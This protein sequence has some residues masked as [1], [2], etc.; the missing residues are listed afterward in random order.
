M[1]D[2]RNMTM[3]IVLAHGLPGSGKSTMLKNLYNK[4]VAADKAALY[5]NMDMFPKHNRGYEGA[6]S[7]AWQIAYQRKHKEDHC[8]NFIDDN[9][10]QYLDVLCM[11]NAEVIGVIM[12]VVARFAEC[13]QCTKYNFTILDFNEDRDMCLKNNAIRTKVNPERSAELT[14]KRANYEV[15]DT[16]AI[17]AE[18]AH[19]IAT[20][21]NY[22]IKD[23]NISV[24]VTLKPVK[25]WNRDAADPVEQMKADIYG[26]ANSIATIKGNLMEGETWRLGGREW[27]YTGEEWSVG[28][29]EPAEFE[30]FDRLM[31]ILVPNI[32]FLQYK[33]VRQAC[34][35]IEE[36]YE[37]DY[38]E[39]YN[40]ARWICDLDKLVESLLKLK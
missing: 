18:V 13:Y 9:T 7:D 29:E 20:S 19:K 16:E 31:E 38:Y 6:L 39:S 10:V 30:T 34:C 26:A 2:G 40:M 22:W 1:R 32:T 27:S 33:K 8:W 36:Y 5:V 17:V 11:S 35:K 21:K 37:S 24:N 25:V 12:A 3:E 23:L 4:D 28:G 14:I 15:L